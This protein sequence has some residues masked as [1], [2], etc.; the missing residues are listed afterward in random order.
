MKPY[1]AICFMLSLNLF[2]LETQADIDPIVTACNV[3]V[4]ADATVN[5]SNIQGKATIQG[6]GSF[7]TGNIGSIYDK[8][9]LTLIAENVKGNVS[10]G[11]VL[12]QRASR[13]DSITYLGKTGQDFQDIN[14]VLLEDSKLFGSLPSNGLIVVDNL[15]NTITLIG[16]DS[17]LNVFR[18]EPVWFN[19]R[20]QIVAPQR[21]SVIVNMPGDHIDMSLVTLNSNNMSENGVDASRVLFNF[22]DATEISLA[23][24]KLWG[25]ILAPM[26]DITSKS[27]S[28]HGSLIANNLTMLTSNLYDQ[29]F[30]GSLPS[31][32]ARAIS[33]PEPS[34]IRLFTISFMMMA[35]V[36]YFKPIC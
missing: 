32:K 2:Q 10:V 30:K 9:D 31:T 20:V 17:E 33:I 25:T 18:T 36:N 23:S 28:I 1:R 8:G 13:I 7:R 34:T 11:G 29:P 6:N 35:L 15:I 5:V 19:Y 24:S 26:A 12:T 4:I 3:F 27:V 16:T 21:S 22:P 14:Q